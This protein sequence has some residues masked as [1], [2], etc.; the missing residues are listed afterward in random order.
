MLNLGKKCSIPTSFPKVCLGRKKTHPTT[1]KV[2]A[3]SLVG[4]IW[5]QPEKCHYL[6]RENKCF[7]TTFLT[8]SLLPNFLCSPEWCSPGECNQRTFWGRGKLSSSILTASRLFYILLYYLAT[9]AMF[10]FSLLFQLFSF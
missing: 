8:V 10:N 5:N 7:L 1:K 9:D 2:L 4:V 3:V 6:N